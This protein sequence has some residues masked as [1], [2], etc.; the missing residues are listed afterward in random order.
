LKVTSYPRTYSISV[1]L[2]IT[3]LCTYSHTCVY[4]YIYVY[5]YMDLTH[6]YIYIYIKSISIDL[7]ISY[8][9]LNIDRHSTCQVE[10]F[11]FSH[12]S[13]HQTYAHI[14][15]YTY[16][17]AHS[18]THRLHIYFARRDSMPIGGEIRSGRRIADHRPVNSPQIS[19]HSRLCGRL[20]PGPKSP[21][22]SP[23]DLTLRFVVI[24]ANSRAGHPW[25]RL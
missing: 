23:I 21:T 16:I 20:P 6:M 13:K 8:Y 12:Q 5:T 25:R 19:T 10:G 4:I 3:R 7:L 9:K 17:H 22:N 14:H 1:A 2:V 11:A 15:T 18:R 24:N